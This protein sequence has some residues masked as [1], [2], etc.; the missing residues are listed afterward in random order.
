VTYQNPAAAPRR[1]W[2]WAVVLIIILAAV[3]IWAYYSTRPQPAQVVVRDIQ[4]FVPLSGQIITPPSARADVPA[5]Y[6]APVDRVETSV[7]KYVNRGDVLV[8]LNLPDVQAAVAQAKAN[9]S[10][11][12]TAYANARKQYDSAAI[13]AAQPQQTVDENGNPVTVTPD[14]N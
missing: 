4:G 9:L 6:R 5:P 10:A 14:S 3:G 8:R 11:A 7:G 12:E 13:S 2:A 1:N